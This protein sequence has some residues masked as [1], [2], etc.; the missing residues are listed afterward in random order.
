[1]TG[2]VDPGIDPARQ[3]LT[4]IREETGLTVVE[5]ED[6]LAGPVL[7]LPDPAGQTWRVHVFTAQAARAEVELNWEHDAVRWITWPSAVATMAL[8]PWLTDLMDAM[9]CPPTTIAA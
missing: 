8:V 7:D 5:L 2:F 1:V 9:T 4:E 6:F 3:A